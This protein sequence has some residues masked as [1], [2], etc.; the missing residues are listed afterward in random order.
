VD[1]QVVPNFARE[2]RH[3]FMRTWYVIDP[4]LI[5]SGFV[6]KVTIGKI[7]YPSLFK[8]S[9]SLLSLT[10]FVQNLPFS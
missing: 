3:A 9:S 10:A 4:K 5:L 1:V 7:E 6:V 2:Q 8:L